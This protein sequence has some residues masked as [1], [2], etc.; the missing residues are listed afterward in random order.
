MSPFEVI[1]LVCFGSGWPF[2][3]AKAVRTKDVSGK[4]PWFMT[5]IC[6]G[7]LSGIVH[8]VIYA[9]DWVIALYA[10]NV[11]LIATDLLLYYRYSARQRARADR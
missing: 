5:I 9:H 2:S 7:Y 8:K 1:M 3:I 11:V 10:L 4:S 6:V